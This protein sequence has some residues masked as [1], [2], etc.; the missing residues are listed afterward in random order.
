M[1]LWRIGLLGWWVFVSLTAF[2]LVEE[3]SSSLDHSS[4]DASYKAAKDTSKPVHQDAKGGIFVRHF[5]IEGVTEFNVASLESLLSD[6]TH[7]SLS[8]GELQEAA[9]RITRYYHVRGY[10]VARAYLPVQAVSNGTVRI[11]VL[12]AHLGTLQLTN[13]SLLRD[14]VAYRYFSPHGT[15]LY[16]PALERQM[17]LLTDAAGVSLRPNTPYIDATLQPGASVGLSDLVMELLPRK[18]V[19]GVVYADTYGDKFTG[20][21]RLGASL[22]LNSPLGVGDQLSIQGQNSFDGRRLKNCIVGNNFRSCINGTG[23][24]KHVWNGL[25]YWLASY[26]IPVP[27]TGLGFGASYQ[28]SHYQLARQFLLLGAHGNAN[29]GSVYG[30]YAFVRSNRYN[31]LGI[32]AYD[33]KQLKDVLAVFSSFNRRR[34]NLGRMGLVFS[35][36]PTITSGLQFTLSYF[37]GD[38]KFQN[39]L[40]AS[41]D[42]LTVRT[43]GGYQ[44]L[45]G[46]GSI[47]WRL[48]SSFLLLF[49]GQGQISNKNLDSS[50]KFVL[51]G[52][53]A[54]RAYAQSTAQGDEG[55]VGSAELRYLWSRQLFGVIPYIS[56]FFDGGKV[57]FNHTPFNPPVLVGPFVLKNTLTLMG[58]G[59]GLGVE[60]GV[61][62]IKA[63]IQVAWKVNAR[64]IPGDNRDPIVWFQVVKTF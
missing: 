28:Q 52:P 10:L 63:S 11:V 49:S 55:Y 22:M 13:H 37:L 57:W 27:G 40:F 36:Y 31:V 33:N 16:G 34:I 53:Y 38:L 41:I 58:A 1:K 8:F 23:A 29:I 60:S 20:I 12:E 9:N 32:A 35:Y 39:P 21:P 47:Y 45:A 61:R 54:V 26:K 64:N 25:T 43:Q 5:V 44:K 7:R 50:E 51:G 62:N 17:L 42:S 59:C 15:T 56:G 14:S 46:L 24:F 30:S 2:G 3:Q 19:T 4:R 6:L 18:R 48:G